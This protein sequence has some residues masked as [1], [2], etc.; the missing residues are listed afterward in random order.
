MSQP[1]NDSVSDGATRMR[2]WWKPLYIFLGVFRVLVIIELA[3]RPPEQGIFCS[4]AIEC[5]DV[6]FG[7]GLYSGTIEHYP[8]EGER[9]SLFP[10]KKNIEYLFVPIKSNYLWA[11]PR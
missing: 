5:L 9:S 1:T 3:I 6:H 11:I 10:L 2:K 4:D 8:L 7:Q